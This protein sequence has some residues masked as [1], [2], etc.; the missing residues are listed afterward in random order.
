MTHPFRFKT[1]DLTYV[2]SWSNDESARVIDGFIPRRR[3][4]PHYLIVDGTGKEWVVPQIHM[5]SKPLNC[6][7]AS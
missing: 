5:S 2:R 6:D 7:D 3:R 4:F 1:G